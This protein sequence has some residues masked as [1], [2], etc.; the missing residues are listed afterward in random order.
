MLII[1]NLLGRNPSSPT[2]KVYDSE[3]R[4]HYRQPTKFKYVSG[5][6][7]EK[8]AAEVGH[9]QVRL[10]VTP[11]PRCA[12]WDRDKLIQGAVVYSVD[13]ITNTALE[14]FF[15]DRLRCWWKFFNWNSGSLLATWI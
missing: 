15:R 4:S 3:Y 10:P 9:Q 1:K 14:R 8:P 6:W 12:P 2:R 7:M 5:V 11:Q 13:L